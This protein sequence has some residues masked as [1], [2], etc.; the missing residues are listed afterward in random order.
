[1]TT[2]P[3]WRGPSARAFCALPYRQSLREFNGTGVILKCLDLRA[4]AV[5]VKVLL[6]IDESEYAAQ[7]AKKVETRLCLPD[8]TVRV[9]HVVRFVIQRANDS[10]NQISLR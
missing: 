3:K 7:A 2:L 8:T 10:M 5:T 4:E 9:I 1:M 6:A